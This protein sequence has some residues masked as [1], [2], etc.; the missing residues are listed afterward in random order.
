MKFMFAGDYLKKFLNEGNDGIPH[1]ALVVTIPSAFYR[2][3]IE[4]GIEEFLKP[5]SVISDKFSESILAVTRKGEFCKLCMNS[6]IS[7]QF[8]QRTTSQTV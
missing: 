6:E 3:A 4:P 8:R 1:L 7:M 2:Y 5:S